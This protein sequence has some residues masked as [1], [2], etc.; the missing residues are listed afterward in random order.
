MNQEAFV[1]AAGRT[2]E[3]LESLYGNGTECYT[4]YADFNSGRSQYAA[5][6]YC[7]DQSGFN[8]DVD[9]INWIQEATPS[10]E[11]CFDYHHWKTVDEITC[12]NYDEHFCN[13]SGYLKDLLSGS[14]ASESCG[15]GYRGDLIGRTFRV[16]YPM[17][18]TVDSVHLMYKQEN[19]G[20][21]R[22]SMPHFL[23]EVMQSLGAGSYPVTIFTKSAMD[24]H[25]S[26]YSQCIEDLCLGNVDICM[27][28]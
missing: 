20:F 14:N 19:N 25:V 2:C 22:G 17:N 15:G 11:T 16:G 9:R 27:G 5:C 4:N 3:T 1:D 24:K 13:W 26:T 28:K 12:D 7:G 8:P 10:N 23:R 6:C 18:G 21:V